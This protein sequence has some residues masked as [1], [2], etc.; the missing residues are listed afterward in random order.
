MLR[1]KT[2]RRPQKGPLSG[3]E[4]RY[5]PTLYNNDAA[6]KDQNN[7]F[8]YAF[9]VYDRDKKSEGG[10]FTQPGLKSGYPP[11]HKVKGK[12]CPDLMARLMGDVPGLRVGSFE[13]PCPKGSSKIAAVI[14]AKRDYHFYRQDSNG[15]WSHKPG[16][17]DVTNVDAAGK[18]IY[19]PRTANR[20]Y[21]KDP[22][23]VLQ[24]DTFCNFMCVPRT[25]AYR[26]K[27][28]GGSKTRKSRGS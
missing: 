11:W 14:D 12:R 22:T 9:N 8:A 5:N 18:L 23:D 20:T 10:P 1:R 16:S 19:D 27:R 17:T 24:Y 4:P 28:G 3:S 6:A 25:R 2:V 26:F 13:Q 21:D 7:C 15:L